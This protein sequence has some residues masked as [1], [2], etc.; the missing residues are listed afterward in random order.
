M[1]VVRLFCPTFSFYRLFLRFLRLDTIIGRISKPVKVFGAFNDLIP[2]NMDANIGLYLFGCFGGAND[3]I[4]N[5]L[6]DFDKEILGK[7]NDDLG[8]KNLGIDIKAVRC[9]VF[10]FC[11]VMGFVICLNS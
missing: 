5:G 4:F 6:I 8:N 11:V 9:A 2:K 10:N 7:L 3:F 1:N